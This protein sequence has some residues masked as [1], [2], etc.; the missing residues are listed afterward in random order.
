MAGRFSAL[1][2][3]RERHRERERE[4]ERRERRISKIFSTLSGLDL[5]LGSRLGT[6]DGRRATEEREQVFDRL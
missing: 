4:R 3:E 5:S 1:A 6:P 2:S